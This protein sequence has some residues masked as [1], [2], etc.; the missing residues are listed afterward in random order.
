[1]N[2]TPANLNAKFWSV[3]KRFGFN[4]KSYTFF[5]DVAFDLFS[6]FETIGVNIPVVLYLNVL[7]VIL[8]FEFW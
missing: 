5:T 1:M 3:S 8:L 7:L 4:A 6:N 2:E